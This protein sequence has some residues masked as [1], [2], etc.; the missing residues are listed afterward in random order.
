MKR[1]LLGLSLACLSI[2]AA[3]CCCWQGSG[4]SPCAW[5]GCGWNA[6]CGDGCD[7]CGGW[8]GWNGWGCGRPGGCGEMYWGDW[9]TADPHCSTCDNGGNWVGP[10]SPGGNGLPPQ[11]YSRAH[12]YGNQVVRSGP[13]R[14]APQGAMMARRSP[15]AEYDP[16]LNHRPGQRQYYAKR[17]APQQQY[18]GR[19]PAQEYEGATQYL[20]TTDRVVKPASMPSSRATNASSVARRGQPTMADPDADYDD[21]PRAQVRRTSQR[22]YVR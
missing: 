22:Q 19:G 5:P 6:G 11:S 20:G 18:A 3:G 14:S 12:P 17:P 13:P 8:G 16:P 9:C 15:P 10:P 21:A 4:W 2:G 7:T 1:L